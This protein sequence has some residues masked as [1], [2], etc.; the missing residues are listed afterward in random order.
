MSGTST[1]SPSSNT[2]AAFE[3]KVRGMYHVPDACEP[4]TNSSVFSRATGST[5]IQKETF[6]WPST[7]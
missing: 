7:Q 1:R 6:W 5:G 4:A 3:T 2:S